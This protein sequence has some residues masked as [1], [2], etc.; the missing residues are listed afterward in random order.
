MT[1]A[2]M[3][4]DESSAQQKHWITHEIGD[5]VVPKLH[6]CIPANQSIMQ[7][8]RHQHDEALILGQRILSIEHKLESILQHLRRPAYLL[9]DSNGDMEEDHCS[10]DDLAMEPVTPTKFCSPSFVSSPAVATFSAPPDWF[11]LSFDPAKNLEGFLR[12]KAPPQKVINRPFS[13][14]NLTAH[15]FW[16]EYF[17]GSPGKM[18]LKTLEETQG[19]SWRSDGKFK[20]LDGKKGTALKAG[21]SLQKPIYEYLE[22]L[23]ISYTE[24]VAF[25]MVQDVFDLFPYKHS[26]K[27]N[28]G[29]C[30][31]E[32]ISHWGPLKATSPVSL[33]LNSSISQD[34]SIASQD[35]LIASEDVPIA[36]KDHPS[37]LV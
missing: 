17:Y 1:K 16:N 20:R 34:D 10:D 2:L 5:K 28:L 36:S 25:S 18:P 21:W 35:D 27:P 7:G 6:A 24:E 8:Q 4:D 15:N 23:M 26:K 22:F 30:K 37:V 29:K 32:F 9:N 11:K 19:S 3:L 31:K 33:D 13:S 12:K 14:S